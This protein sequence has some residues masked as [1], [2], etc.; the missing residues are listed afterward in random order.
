MIEK[1]VA[2]DGSK[3]YRF[4]LGS[5]LAM[6]AAYFFVSGRERPH[7]AC[8]STQLGCAV[9]CPFCAASGETFRRNLTTDEIVL[10]ISTIVDGALAQGAEEGKIE[11]SFMGMGEPLANLR[12]L[13]GAIA[14]IHERY[15]RITRVSVS[16]AGPAARID[17]L[18]QFMPVLPRLHLQISLHATNDKVRCL[19]VPKAPDSVDRLLEAGHRFNQVT[20]D[21]VCLNYVLLRGIND[22]PSDAH[23]LARLNPAVFYIKVTKLNPTLGLPGYIQGAT[24][25]EIEQFCKILGAEGMPYKIFVGDGLDVQASCGQ[26]AARP[27]ELRIPL[28]L[29]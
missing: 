3:K 15:P 5:G 23:W 9:G 4:S 10:E 12:N 8:V 1:S 7:I 25:A 26:M 14:R 24:L 2:E 18:S 6:E 17:N 13:L 11:I 19:L 29:V 28:E 21:H 20:G 27:V 16:T 22:S